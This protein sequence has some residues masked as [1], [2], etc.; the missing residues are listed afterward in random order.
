MTSYNNIISDHKTIVSRVGSLGNNLT[1]DIKDRITFD[2]ESHLKQKIPQEIPSV[3]PNKQKNK[4][5]ISG[6]NYSND[7]RNTFTRRFNNQDMTTCWLNSCLQLIL[8]AIDY[9]KNTAER[10]LTS[11]LGMELIKLRSKSGDETLDPVF[12]KDIIVTSEDTRIAMRL[13]DL[14]YAIIDQNLL[15]E[16][17]TRIRNNRLDLRNGQQCVRDFFLCL[18]ENLLSWPD[19][20]STFSFNLTNSS[21]CSSCKHRNQFETNQ[22]YVEMAVPPNHA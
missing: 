14:S 7:K 10:K 17:S 8:I 13:S 2:Q 19:V 12:V 9:N 20:F 4:K 18:N 5:R 22:L 15:E 16:Q 1:I 11:E 3:E 6:G 21:E